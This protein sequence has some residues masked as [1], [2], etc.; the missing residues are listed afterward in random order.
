MMM[1]INLLLTVPSAPIT[2]GINT[3]FMFHSC[4]F[5][6]NSLARSRYLC[7]FSPSF[8]FTLWS[9]GTLLLFLRRLTYYEIDELLCRANFV[10]DAKLRGWT[11][12]FIR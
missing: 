7:Q 1:M 5:F 9:A 10:I 4:C 8:G 12:K 11:E 3:K 2:T 6:F